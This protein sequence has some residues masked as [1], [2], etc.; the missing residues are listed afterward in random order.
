MVEFLIILGSLVYIGGFYFYRQWELNKAE[1]IR[2]KNQL[3]ESEQT[4]IELTKQDLV[5]IRQSIKSLQLDVENLISSKK[6][7]AQH[8]SDIE[9]LKQDYCKISDTV[10]DLKKINSFETSIGN[11]NFA[12]NFKTGKPRDVV[13][14]LD[15][16]LLQ[17]QI[18]HNAINIPGQA[19]S[20]ET[21]QNTSN[22]LKERDSLKQPIKVLHSHINKVEKRVSK[23][24][25]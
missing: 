3:S 7:L 5:N 8:F 10:M 25:G 15:Y 18:I 16:R 6:A 11:M 2:A 13:T 17:S 23:K 20:L 21:V 12:S 19:E 14:D 4:D 9:A 22:M 1:V 24:A